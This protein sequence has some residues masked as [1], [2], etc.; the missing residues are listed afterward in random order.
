MPC[1]SAASRPRRRA[2]TRRVA[3]SRVRRARRPRRC[4]RG[5][6]RT[7]RTRAPRPATSSPASLGLDRR[8][9]RA[10]HAARLAGADAERRAVV[11]V[12]RS[13]WTS[14]TSRQ[15]TRTAGRAAR[16]CRR[17][18]ARD[19]F[20]GREVHAAVVARS[21]AAIR[22]RSSS[23]SSSRVAPM[24]SG[25]PASSTRMFGFF[26]SAASALLPI[27]GA[28]MTSANCWP[29]IASAEGSSSGRLNAMTPPNADVGSVR[30]ASC[31]RRAPASRPTAM[32]Q[33]FACFTITHAAL[34]N[35]LTA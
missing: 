4:R 7:R 33:G 6:G 28:M 9:A 12:A 2:S 11:R 32:P 16:T 17:C 14:R 25:Q 3:R 8:D 5:T 21:A 18:A 15:S 30:Y 24:R 19:D 1:S 34:S 13:R 20:R 35:A 31:I 29:T 22:R 10:H 26:A 23:R 27:S